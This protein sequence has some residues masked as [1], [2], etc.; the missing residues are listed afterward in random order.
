MSAAAGCPVVDQD[1][2][3][4]GFNADPYPVLEEWRA[5]GPV[6]FN[7]HDER[8]LV[9]SFRG[10]TRVLSTL[11]AF[12]SQPGAETVRRIFGGLTMMAID[13]PRHHRMR[14]VWA[15]DFRRDTLAE[16][17][18]ELVTRI[19]AARVGPFAERLRAGEVLDAVGSLTRAIPTLV[20]AEMLGVE[21]EM[22]D[23]FSAWSDAIGASAAANVPD[24]TPGQRAALAASAEA[25]Q[26]LN[27]Y[28]AEAVTQ[29]RG[30]PPADDLVS[31][32]VHADFAA[33]MDE[34]EIV[35]SNTQMVFAGNE[36]TAKLMA[37]ALVALA[38][39]PDQRRALVA[40]R[41]LIPQAVEE[42]H[43]WS[44]VV[45]TDPRWAT[46]DA[47]EVEGVTVPRG[48]AVT[49]VLGAANRDPQRWERP[50]EFD[51][52][53]PVRGH[54]GFGFGIHVCL[55]IHLARLEVAVLLD[56]LL[57]VLPDFELAGPVDFGR[58]FSLRGP[59]AVPLAAG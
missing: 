10:S 58:S 30:R 19:V 23:R 33:E 48:A 4:P 37:T 26:Q 42:V 15:P 18:R 51:V 47:S 31:R 59:L 11:D 12:D 38:R 53:R 54:L 8:Y 55:G 36:T 27:R 46:G 7:A 29:R 34:S 1:L 39:H 52:A 9:L 16:R 41:S 28:M 3:D 2:S 43:R 5:R 6:V 25:T 49:P 13:T 24:P 56:R 20:I 35:A 44:T 40:D 14:D 17:R 32:M 22:V 21:P 50:A 57:D 45:Q